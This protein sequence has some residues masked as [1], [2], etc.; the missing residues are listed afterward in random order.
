MQDFSHPQYFTNL[1]FPDFFRGCPE[2]NLSHLLAGFLGRGNPSRLLLWAEYLENWIMMTFECCKKN[3]S[4]YRW[5]NRNSDGLL[6]SYLPY[7]HPPTS[8]ITAGRS[9]ADKI[10]TRSYC[11]KVCIET[12]EHHFLWTWEHYMHIATLPGVVWDKCLFQWTL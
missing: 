4:P 1:N 2:T 10:S 7:P 6:T 5:F 8:K 9:Q 3:W 12:F 11:L